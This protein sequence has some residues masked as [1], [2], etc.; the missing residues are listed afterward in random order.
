MNRISKMAMF[1]IALVTMFSLAEAKVVT[2]TTKPDTKA[3]KTKEGTTYGARAGFSLYSYSSGDSDYDKYVDMGY[4]FGVAL[5]I[6]IPINSSISFVPEPGFL[7]RK[8][9]V[10]NISQT[11]PMVGSYKMEMYMTEFALSVPAM[12]QFTPVE[13]LPFYLA[14]GVQL[15]IPIAS[16]MTMTVGG[17]TETAKT[18]G[19]RAVD[20]GIPLGAGYFVT[21]S[22]GV[23]FRAVIGVTSPSKDGDKDGWN[24]YGLG[25]TYLF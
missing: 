17:K 3:N 2:K 19:R 6:N 12:L 15:D 23:D 20:F 7:Y 25:L 21:P 4:G 22:I 11:I 18:D 1:L 5:V 9:M 24:Q 13:N 8:P 10:V 16:E 14:A